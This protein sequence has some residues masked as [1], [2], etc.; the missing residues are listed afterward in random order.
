[1]PLLIYPILFVILLV[2]G[3][4]HRAYDAWAQ[5]WNISVSYGL[6]MLHGVVGFSWGFCA[7]LALI[8][9][10]CVWKKCS[11]KKLR[12]G[13]VKSFA[14]Q[15]PSI[16]S[17]ANAVPPTSTVQSASTTTFVYPRESSVDDAALL[18]NSNAVLMSNSL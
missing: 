15:H 9:Q 17:N 7:G 8:V 4:L 14:V 16:Y 10:L 12:W 18:S 1:M 13:S 5:P 3:I 6:T 11:K 2:F